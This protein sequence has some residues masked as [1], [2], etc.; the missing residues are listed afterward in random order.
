MKLRWN[1]KKK[2]TNKTVIK[3]QDMIDQEINFEP[4]AVTQWSRSDTQ[5]GYFNLVD[6]IDKDD[7][8]DT[9]ISIDGSF[10]IMVED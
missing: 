2:T 5:I 8:A 9:E 4:D 1:I 10:P 7:R 6:K 3:I